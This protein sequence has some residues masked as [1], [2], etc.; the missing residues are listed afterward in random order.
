MSKATPDHL[1]SQRRIHVLALDGGGVRGLSS[2]LLL[3]ELM[4]RLGVKRGNVA[5]ASIRPSECFDLI[6]GTGTGGISALLLGR[7]GMTV[8][9]AIDEYMRMAEAAFKPPVSNP[10]ALRVWREKPVLDGRGLERAMGDVV[11]KILGDR[12]ASLKV[13][14]E[15]LTTC[16]TAVLAVTSATV[17]AP[18]HVF[19]SYTVTQPASQFPIH[20]VARATVSTADLFAPVL[21]G[22]SPV[23]FIDAGLAG[24]NNPAEVGLAEAAALWP[25]RDIDC[26]VSLGTGLQKIVCVDQGWGKVAEACAAIIHSCEQVHDRVFRALRDS[27]VSYFRFNVDR[28]LAAVDIMEWNEAGSQGNLAGTTEAY[29]RWA[30]VSDRLDSSV[31]TLNGEMLGECLRILMALSHSFYSLTAHA[32]GHPNSSQQE[33]G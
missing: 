17:D 33:M 5:P 16:R 9:E 8:G 7:L 32:Q 26:L 4:E 20:A 14:S 3:R 6:I 27:G 31:R 28:G 18:P 30:E 24:Y 25:G 2:L 19:R 22:N 15:D 29:M 23:R 1:V 11:Q 12:D 13:P 21:L 10:F